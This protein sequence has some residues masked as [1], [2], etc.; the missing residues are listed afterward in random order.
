[1][2]EKILASLIVGFLEAAVLTASATAGSL[3]ADCIKMKIQENLARK[4][5]KQVRTAD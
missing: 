5:Q 2:K 4:N 1:M 3:F